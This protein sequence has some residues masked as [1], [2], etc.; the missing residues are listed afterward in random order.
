MEGGIALLCHKV[1]GYIW[2]IID[3]ICLSATPDKANESA[4]SPLALVSGSRA[5]NCWGVTEV[6]PNLATKRVE[7]VRWERKCNGIPGGLRYLPLARASNLVT[8][9]VAGAHPELLTGL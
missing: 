8:S 6:S 3:P 7:G 2:H 1:F 9:E 5:V 4:W